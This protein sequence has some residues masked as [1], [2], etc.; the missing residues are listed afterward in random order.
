[1]SRSQVRARA[2]VDTAVGG[3]VVMLLRPGALLLL[4]IHILT[5]SLR[6]PTKDSK[7]KRLSRMKVIV[8]T[9]P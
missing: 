6:C 8:E 9:S 4:A 7:N 1:M 3:N 5:E 2:V